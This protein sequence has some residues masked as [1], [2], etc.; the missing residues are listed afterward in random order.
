MQEIRGGWL[1]HEDTAELLKK[2]HIGVA[3][4][5]LLENFYFEPVKILEYM[6][7]GLAIIAS[8]QGRV[9]ELVDDERTGLL[10]SPGDISA[11]ADALI[12]LS[13]DPALRERL[14]EQARTALESNQTWEIT[15]QRVLALCEEAQ[16]S[17]HNS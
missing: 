13:D 7:A 17:W 15:A 12:R 14:G 6:A 11:L 4:Y 16:K 5:L 2:S 8:K 9:C 1:P 10:V 3:P